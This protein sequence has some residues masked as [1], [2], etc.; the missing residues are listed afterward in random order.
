MAKTYS[1]FDV[2]PIHRNDQQ[3][4][5]K[6]DVT[7]K[8]SNQRSFTYSFTDAETYTEGRIKDIV[9]SIHERDPIARRKCIEHYGPRC[10]ICKFDFASRYGPLFEGLIHV[11][12]RTPLYLQSENHPVDPILDL[13]PVCPNCHMVL[14]SKS[15][16][17]Y[18]PEDIIEFIGKQDV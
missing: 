11:H 4:I 17:V 15:D 18:T 16:G 12:H 9:L 14:H 3:F 7:E 1:L 8:F 2:L 6:A 13:I 10:Y 5:K